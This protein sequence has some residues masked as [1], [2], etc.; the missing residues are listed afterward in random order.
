MCVCVYI[1]VSVCV[2]ARVC[3]YLSGF[4]DIEHTTI[5][6]TVGSVIHSYAFEL[7]SGRKITFNERFPSIFW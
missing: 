4:T 1:Y 5:T 7:L 3:G 6:V 2:R